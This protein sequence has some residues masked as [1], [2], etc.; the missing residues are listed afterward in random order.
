MVA[1]LM[2][3]Q[4]T[5]GVLIFNQWEVA[6]VRSIFAQIKSRPLYFIRRI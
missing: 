1:N 2:K 5:G 3:Q 4:I 6:E